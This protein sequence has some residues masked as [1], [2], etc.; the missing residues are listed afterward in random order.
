MGWGVGGETKL[1]PGTTQSYLREAD[2]GDLFPR[3]PSWRGAGPCPHGEAACH[4]C[5]PPWGP[6]FVL[7]IPQAGGTQWNP[8]GGGWPRPPVAHCCITVI[9][10]LSQLWHKANRTGRVNQCC[11]RGAPGRPFVSGAQMSW[12]G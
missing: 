2:H 7:H 3:A 12:G 10:G 5:S 1:P 11:S 4:P 8:E 9:M 6:C